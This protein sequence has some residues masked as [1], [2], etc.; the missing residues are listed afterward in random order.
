VSTLHMYLHFFASSVV[1]AMDVY[2]AAPWWLRVHVWVSGLG[3]DEGPAAKKWFELW[4][5]NRKNVTT[6]DNEKCFPFMSIQSCKYQLKP[7]VS[8]DKMPCM[9]KYVFFNSYHAIISTNLRRSSTTICF[10]N[11]STY[12]NKKEPSKIK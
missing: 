5:Y 1:Y 6:H 9:P 3:W 7:R 4:T 11:N 10:C 8:T 12:T 2:G